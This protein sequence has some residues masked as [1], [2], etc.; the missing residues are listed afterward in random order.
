MKLETRKE[1]KKQ[2]KNGAK[3]PEFHRLQRAHYELHGRIGPGLGLPQP[4][5]SFFTKNSEAGKFMQAVFEE[6]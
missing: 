1:W 3:M 5:Q 6:K 4:H 2:A